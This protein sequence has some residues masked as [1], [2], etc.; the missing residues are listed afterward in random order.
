[1]LSGRNASLRGMFAIAVR[2]DLRDEAAARAFDAERLL[3]DLIAAAPAPRA[4]FL[5]GQCVAGSAQ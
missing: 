3:S 2:F 5:A 1:M 4:V